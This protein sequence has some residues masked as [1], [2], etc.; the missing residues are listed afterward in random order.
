M[1]SYPSIEIHFMVLNIVWPLQER[2]NILPWK[3]WSSIFDMKRLLTLCYFFRLGVIDVQ[4]FDNAV[5]CIRVSVD[6]IHSMYLLSTV[7]LNRPSSISQLYP[8]TSIMWKRFHQQQQYT[9]KYF[10]NGPVHKFL[11]KIPRTFLSWCSGRI[12]SSQ[13]FDDER[14]WSNKN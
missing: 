1:S 5:A 4:K 11:V 6:S 10:G 3:L 8:L 12:I 9:M 7:S 2:I 13:W 14:E